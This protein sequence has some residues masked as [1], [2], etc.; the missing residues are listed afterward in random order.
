MNALNSVA[1]AQPANPSM[2]IN[3]TALSTYANSFQTLDLFKQADGWRALNFDGGFNE[4]ENVDPSYFDAQGWPVR[5][6]DGDLAGDIWFTR[7]SFS[8]ELPA[9]RYVL[10]W[11][12]DG[13]LGVAGEVVE[14]DGNR[15][16]FEVRDGALGDDP[17]NAIQV[18][19]DATDTEGDGDYVRNVQVFREEDEA[20][21]DAGE[22]W[23]PTY[24]DQIGQFRVVRAMD[25]TGTNGSEVTE[26]EATEERL[27]QAFWTEKAPVAAAVDL[28]NEVNADLWLNIPHLA[29][30]DYV[31]EAA[32]FVRDNLDPEL[33]VRVEYTNEHWTFGFGQREWLAERGA[34]LLGDDYEYAREEFYALRSAETI[35]L[36]KDVFGDE[37]RVDGV[38]T[39]TA[40]FGTDAA[41]IEALFETPRL[42]ALGLGSPSGSDAFDIV[43]VDTYYDGGLIFDE[44]E[45][46]AKEWF[47]TLPEDEARDRLFEAMNTGEGFVSPYTFEELAANYATYRNIADANGWALESY[48]GGSFLITRPDDPQAYTDFI[49]SLNR[50]PRIGE[51]QDRI[52]DTWIAEGGELIAHFADLGYDGYFGNWSTYDSGFATEPNLRGEGV[53]ARNAGDPWYDTEGRDPG[54]FLDDRFRDEPGEPDDPPTDPGTSINLILGT[55]GWD[56]LT[57]TGGRDEIRGLGSGDNLEG[58]AGDDRLFGGNGNDWLFGGEGNDFLVGG[59]GADGLVGAGGADRLVGGEGDDTVWG[60]L[61]DDRIGG[62]A[63]RDD[64]NGDDGDDRI[65]GGADDDVLTG[66]RGADWLAGADGDDVLLGGLGRDRLAGGNGDDRIDG[67]WDDDAMSGGAGG[68]VFVVDRWYGRDVVLDFEV[69]SDRID[70]SALD[71][72]RGFE[73]VAASLSGFGTDRSVLTFAEDGTVL[74]LRGVDP[75]TLGPDDFLL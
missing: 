16:V 17:R 25:L 60:G 55:D 30:D 29:S 23:R 50:D 8:E 41:R 13:E 54:I 7:V 34:A 32:A 36:F 53:V 71:L 48:E 49:M 5:M 66:G 70:V 9:G 37:G 63:G 40:G 51:F 24:L 15:I 68:D 58:A 12:G 57:G 75:S 65:N 56:G 14:R 67:A 62:S 43:A 73:S 47:A 6:P 2:G 74:V 28:A 72:E 10:R 42:E 59:K 4:T 45:A 46:V 21:V 27:D 1:T 44:N 35:S 19:L 20:L 38:I 18:Y 69:G 33:N 39:H 11:E 64:L 3:A 31:R 22:I 61:G 52:Y 26:W